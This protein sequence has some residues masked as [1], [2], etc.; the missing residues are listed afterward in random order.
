M[1]AN[2]DP[3]RDHVNGG[4]A[5]PGILEVHVYRREEAHKV[6][7]HE[8][9][10]AIGLDIPA[11]LA[12]P[13]KTQFET[14]LDRRFWPHFFEAFTEFYAEWLWCF[15]RAKSLRDATRLWDYQLKCS[16]SQAAAVW[17][18]IHDAKSEDTNVFA[19][20]VLKW[21]LMGHTDEMLVSPDRSVDRWFTWWQAARPRLEELAKKV[22]YTESESV[23]MGMTC[24]S[25]FGAKRLAS[26]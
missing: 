15:V 13:V 8:T 1:P 20:Y 14:V 12:E 18:R 24:S 6:L 16:E 26:I 7:I 4:W 17:A 2:V 25:Y 23:R 11:S 19:Y 3:G 22:A 21:V 5:I 9:I 10:H